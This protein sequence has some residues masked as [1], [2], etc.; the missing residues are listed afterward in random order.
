MLTSTISLKELERK[1]FRST[2][3]DGLWDIYQGGIISSFTVFAGALD[4][5]DHLTSW[6][7]LGIFLVGIGIS[8]L[9][10][11]A[12]K[13]YITL[14]RIGQV[15]FGPARQRRKRT[16]VAVMSGIVGL[17]VVIFA[18]TVA[19]WQFPALR[20]WFGFLAIPQSMG[21]L[22]V[23]VVGALFV[24]PSLSLVAYFNDFQRGYYIAAVMSSAVFCL[25]WFESALLMLVA[26]M[27]VFLPG[28]FLFIRF[29]IQHPLHP[30]E[31]QND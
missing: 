8:Y 16:L 7:R 28:V 13:K 22:I 20:S 10:F 18:F 26:G 27:L 17:Q 29:L 11:W 24:G 3:Q 5:N 23:A 4:T 9:V 14:P 25:F 30:Q 15:K 31:N 2:Y 19:L 6:Q 1:A 12:G 21:T